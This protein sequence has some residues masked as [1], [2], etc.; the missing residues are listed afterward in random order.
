MKIPSL[1]T[2]YRT[3]EQ[4]KA[5]FNLFKNH[6]KPMTRGNQYIECKDYYLNLKYN[7]ESDVLRW[8]HRGRYLVE[9][10]VNQLEGGPSVNIAPF[11]LFSLL[12]DAL[13]CMVLTEEKAVEDLEKQKRGKNVKT[14]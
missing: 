4:K 12:D 1:V 13:L 3:D 9:V 14:S 6:F 2:G 5:R 7:E 8:F 11:A 10:V